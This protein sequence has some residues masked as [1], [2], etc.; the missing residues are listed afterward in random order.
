MKVKV[1]LLAAGYGKRFG[2]KKQFLKLKGEPLFQYSLNT[3]NKIDIVQ[4]TYLVLPQE[5]LERIKIFSFKP[6]IKIAGGVQRQDSV[7][8]ALA[9][10]K[11]CDI[12]II[13]DSA[14]PFATEEMFLEAIE[15]VKKG[16]DGSIT[17]I[18]TTDTIKKYKGDLI[19]ETLNRDELL[20]AQTPQAFSFEKIKSAHEKAKKENITGTDDA[21]LMER[22]GYRITYNQ[23]SHLNIKITTKEDLKLAEC[24]SNIQTPKRKPIF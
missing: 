14:R 11:E 10:I 19:R 6:V 7:Y 22:A 24:I 15:N 23:G 8:N 21:Y 9:H 12:V 5:D 13:H 4:E 3:I 2:E 18:K 20:Q 16:F 17:A 1:I